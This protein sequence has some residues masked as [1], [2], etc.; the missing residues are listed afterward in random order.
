[1]KKIYPILILL[2]F[3]ASGQAQQ[4]G[5][6]YISTMRIGPFK[7]GA[8]K[9]EIETIINKP[10]ILNDDSEVKITYKGSVYT[11]SFQVGEE[12]DLVLSSIKSSDTPLKTKSG[13]GIGS[14]K[15]QILGIYDKY[16]INIQNWY[17]DSNSGVPK[18][19]VQGIA[20]KDDDAGTYILFKTTDR[21]VTEITVCYNDED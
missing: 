16:S 12:E 15:M 11:L 21:I 7:L 19:K 3:C 6:D 2:L 9:A 10:I 8:K 14:N 18:D 13:V 5:S 17:D 1:M 20:L 4:S